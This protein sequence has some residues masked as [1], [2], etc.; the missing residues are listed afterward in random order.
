M[1]SLSIGMRLNC[2]NIVTLSLDVGKKALRHL[3]GKHWFRHHCGVWTSIICGG[4]SVVRRLAWCLNPYVRF[5]HLVVSLLPAD[6][7]YQQAP[8]MARC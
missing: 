3:R 7:T 6:T 5:H 8:S 2:L 1:K 4:S